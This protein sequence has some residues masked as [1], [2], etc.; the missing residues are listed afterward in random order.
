M[1]NHI[2]GS[3]SMNYEVHNLKNNL[4]TI[5]V[6]LPGT[7]AASAQIW[8]KAGSTLEDKKDHGIAHFLEHMFFKGTQTRPGAMIAHEVESFGGEINAFTS[9][10]YTCYYINSPSSY[11]KNSIDIIL[12]MVSNPMFKEE[13]II[14]E[15]EVVFE[16]FRRSIDNPGQYSFSQIQKACFQGGYKHAILGNEK[17]IKSFTREQLISFRKAHYNNANAF[18]VI[19]GDLSKDKEKI[20]NTIE[21]YKLPSGESSKRK[22]F[23]LKKNDSIEIHNK[24]VKMCQLT[25]TIEAPGITKSELAAED[26]AYNVMGHG[27]SSIL[28]RS[29]VLKNAIANSCNCSTMVFSDGGIHFL[30]VKFPKENTDQVLKTLAETLKKVTNDGVSKEDVTKIKNQYIASKVFE[31]ES[32]ESFSFSVGHSYAQTNDLDRETIFLDQVKK[33]SASKVSEAYQFIFSRPLHFSL[34]LPLGEEKKKYEKKIEAF[35]KKIKPT[36]IKEKSKRAKIEKSKYDPNLK[37]IELKPGLKLLYRQ[38]P[39]NPTFVLHAYFQGGI[40]AETKTNNGIYNLLATQ[41]TKGYKGLNEE[42]LSDIMENHS[43]TFGSFSG[44]NAYGMTLHGLS[45][46]F[47]KLS[48]IFMQNLL[49]PACTAKN[50]NLEKKLILRHIES[51]FQDPTR[52]CF[53]KVNEEL[54]KNHPYG[55]SSLGTA[56]TIKK[57]KSNDLKELHQKTLRT[58]EVL[59][60]YCGDMELYELINTLQPFIDQI[61]SKKVKPLKHKKVK[62]LKTK[63]THIN[64]DREQ[65]QIFI[66]T[67]TIAREEDLVVLK[68][69]SSFLSGQSSELFVDVR[70]R[71]GLCYV[72]QP[73][74]LNALEAGF[75]G[76]YMASGHDKVDEAIEAINDIIHRLRTKGISQKDFNR[77]KKMI[78]GQNELSLQINDDF[79]NVY[80]AP[81]L[82]GLGLDYFYHTNETIKDMKYPAFKKKLTEVL[83]NEWITTTVG[84]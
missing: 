48:P 79:A 57:I 47:E 33:C 8:F 34:Q 4:E 66:G 19:A 16:E 22:K 30:R 70:D 2:K 15:R 76:I 74:F 67:Q 49:T 54:F 35:A 56:Q 69:L 61:P 42:K 52:R 12:D 17:T 44:K 55:M 20:I 58:K 21:Q 45:D 37:A 36:K 59:L 68:M 65:T 1:I 26:L 5:F 75:W 72:A 6:D 9:F 51:N 83:S 81:Y 24:D 71:K 10:D 31:K 38:N 27:E 29:M 41:L 13:D 84:K 64:F 53:S 40:A 73:I 80:S 39:M 18:L 63:K 43:A 60:T 78:E 25:L 3:I 77:I 46:F 14:P 82:Q 11:L 7:G 28:Y 32:I 50:L 23:S 62:K